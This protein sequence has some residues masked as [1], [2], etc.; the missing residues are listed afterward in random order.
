M[1]DCLRKYYK[2]GTPII[3][4]ALA[5]LKLGRKLP[6][7]A[8]FSSTPANNANSTGRSLTVFEGGNCGHGAATR[9]HACYEPNTKVCYSTSRGCGAFFYVAL[10]YLTIWVT[11][12]DFTCHTSNYSLR[13]LLTLIDIADPSWRH[14]IRMLFDADPGF[15]NGLRVLTCNTLPC[16]KIYFDPGTNKDVSIPT[17]L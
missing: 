12:I 6:L 7:L 3:T 13:Q 4:K 14:H 1:K 16:K 2:A 10:A 5:I 8:N 15:L 9:T 11:P 17:V